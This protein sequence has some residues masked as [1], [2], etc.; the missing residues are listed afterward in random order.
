MVF[1]FSLLNFRFQKKCA[2][3]EN[4]PTQHRFKQKVSI[5]ISD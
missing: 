1:P 5:L 2:I 3:L 4:E